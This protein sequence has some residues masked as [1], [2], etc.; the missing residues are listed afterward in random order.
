[1]QIHDLKPAEGATHR[2]I[3][4]G[5]GIG[6]G[7]GKTSGRG[8]KG[9]KARNKVALG[10]EGGHTPLH[11]RLP[12]VRGFKPVNRIAYAAVNIGDLEPLDDGAEVTPQ[13]MFELGLLRDAN[14]LVK[15][16]GDGELTKKLSVRAH[17]FS[18]TA[19]SKIEALGG[20]AEVL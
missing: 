5:R 9:Q 16:L 3:K 18:G 19:V 17:K 13:T 2:R 8:H 4:V 1:M 14:E 20:T 11:R 12:Q 10:F 7:K 15:V 6:S